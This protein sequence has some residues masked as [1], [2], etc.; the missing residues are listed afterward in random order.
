M[1]RHWFWH[2]GRQ[3][4]IKKICLAASEL[5]YK[6]VRPTQVA[7]KTRQ[8]LHFKLEITYKWLFLAS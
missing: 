8:Y 5:L 3:L 7:E 6:A 2:S 1:L 4:A